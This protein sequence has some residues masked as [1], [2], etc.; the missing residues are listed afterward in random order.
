MSASEQ[1]IAHT[2]LDAINLI[3]LGKPKKKQDLN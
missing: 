3:F 2:P 1:Y